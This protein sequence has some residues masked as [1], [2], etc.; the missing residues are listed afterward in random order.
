MSF[1]ILAA[2]AA[3]DARQAAVVRARPL[4]LVVGSCDQA[5]RQYMLR[6]MAQRCR[7][8]LFSATVPT[9]ELPYL[10]GY[11]LVD[12]MDHEAMIELARRHEE[13][14]AGVV[15]YW[16][17]RVEA[18]AQVASALGLPTSPVESFRACRD[19]YLS[20]QLLDEAQV[21]QAE[22]V[23]VSSAAEAL[24]A[25]DRI[26]YPVV[27]KPRVLASSVGVALAHD[28]AEL[29]DAFERADVARFAGVAVPEQAVL[30]E[31]YLDGPEISVDSV[32]VDG[33]VVPLIVARKQLG[34]AP[35][36]EEIGHVVRRDDPLLTD[37]ALLAVLQSAHD[38]LGLTRAMTHTELRLTEA[39]PRVVEVNARTGGG[40]IPRLGFITTGIDLGR[41]CAELAVGAR[42]DLR[43]RR[44]AGWDGPAV[45]AVRFLYP[46]HDMV[47]ESAEVRPERLP[48]A[49][50]DYAVLVE[51]GQQVRLPP[52]DHLHC[53]Y[54]LVI[55]TADSVEECAAEL[56]RAGAAFEIRGI[57]LAGKRP[58]N[59]PEIANDCT[60]GASS[61]R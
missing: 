52:H 34:F 4:L 44:P 53:R 7:L 25:A 30:I 16:E 43:P 33:R 24:E 58:A 17:T 9:W 36:F 14:F 50:V 23:A 20:R 5:W 57:P 15:T 48:D 42:L 8:H 11:D 2:I 59:L 45:A 28:E 49:V 38:A 12:T 60:I 41:L 27:V 47:V 37:S 22:A 39:G 10:S 26:G 54:A 40:M 6:S 31:E 13:P 51:P 3:H 32:C 18:A 35:A 1:K 61:P 29:V 19:K 21:P 46:S 56:D 55:A